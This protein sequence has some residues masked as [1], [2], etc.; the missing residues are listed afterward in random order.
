V[1]Q[2]QFDG[3]GVV[4]EDGEQERRP[5]QLQQNQGDQTSLL[6]LAKNVALHIDTIFNIFNFLWGVGVSDPLCVSS[7]ALHFF[8]IILFGSTTLL[9]GNRFAV[10]PS[11]GT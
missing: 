8:P 5:A 3:V 10:M 4:R 7:S 6:K 11:L 9:T 1:L 2:Q